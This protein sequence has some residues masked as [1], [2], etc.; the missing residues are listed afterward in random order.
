M[1]HPGVL[2]HYLGSPPHFLGVSPPVS[3]RGGW[4]ARP[5]APAAAPPAAPHAA[6]G[7]SPPL[8]RSPR[9]AG[10]GGGAK[11]HPCQ[12]QPPPHGATT[13]P[14]GATG[15]P[16]DGGFWGGHGDAPAPKLISGCPSSPP[17][18]TVGES[19]PPVWRCRGLAAG[20]AQDRAPARWPVSSSWQRGWIRMGLSGSGAAS[21]LSEATPG[22]GAGRSGGSWDL[23]SPPPVTVPARRDRTDAT[24]PHRPL[25]PPC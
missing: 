21:E 2:P 14:P 23:V 3:Q 13:A 24:C 7:P 1:S 25:F 6:A 9:T 16:R 18:P 15:P 17:P 4:D 19:P 11:T 20:G 22:G 12:Q 8:Q 10:G 5:S